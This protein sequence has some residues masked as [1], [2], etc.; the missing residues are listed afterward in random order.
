MKKDWI[1]IILLIVLAVVLCMPVKSLFS[2]NDDD[3]E[4]QITHVT[5]AEDGEEYTIPAVEGQVI[6]MFREDVTE[7][8]VREILADNDIQVISKLEQLNYYLLG[9]QPGDE[10][11]LITRLQSCQ[12]VGFV[13]PDVLETL[14]SVQPCVIDGFVGDHGGRVKE[15]LEESCSDLYVN[16]YDVSKDNGKSVSSNKVDD[17]LY[18]ILSNMSSSESV[19]I[20]MSFGPRLENSQGARASGWSDPDA[21]RSAY[22][23]QYRC[24]MQRLVKMV[25]RYDNLDFVITKSSGNVGMKHMEEI[26]ADIQ[27]YLSPEEN[28]VFERHFMIVS[29]KDDYCSSDYSND[30]T[31]GVTNPMVVKVD[32]SDKTAQSPSWQ[33][34]SFSSPRFAGCIANAAN[35]LNLKVVDVLSYARL[36]NTKTSNGVISCDQ[37]YSESD[38]EKEKRFTSPDL[39]WK[40][41]QGHVKQL[42]QIEK[43]G[44]AVYNFDRQGN[45][46]SYDD[47]YS[48]APYRIER[49]KNGQIVGWCQWEEENETNNYGEEYCYNSDGYICKMNSGDYD[50]ED[51]SCEYVLNDRGWPI[52]AKCEMWCVGNESPYKDKVSYS[53][54]NIDTHGNWLKVKVITTGQFENT[55]YSYAST[56]TRK[57]TYWE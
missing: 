28:R 9:V 38:R 51:K 37:I 3:E 32:I 43:N 5:L 53:Y 23:Y 41:L 48:D 2:E 33:G 12:E 45:F 47:S 52:S 14:L 55:S 11:K 19:V 56:I 35:A 7:D 6:V 21:N 4:S 15:M 27:Q 46:I 50:E 13:G 39:K 25:S 10:G 16:T 22:R 17:A 36:A 57:I 24:T 20:N 18:R 1:Y 42:K 44:Y 26:V 34:T 8:R 54:S 49:N 30:V 31:P 29:A 40:Q